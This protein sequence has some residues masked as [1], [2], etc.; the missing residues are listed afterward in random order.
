MAE[1]QAITWPQYCRAAAKADALMQVT[2]WLEK[3]PYPEVVRRIEEKIAQ[4]KK[5]SDAYQAKAHS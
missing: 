4:H 5:V 2:Y 3:Y 1:R